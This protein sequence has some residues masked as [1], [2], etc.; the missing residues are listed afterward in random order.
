VRG[1]ATTAVNDTVLSDQ[2]LEKTVEIGYQGIDNVIAFTAL[3]TVPQAYRDNQL[4]IPTG[5]LTYEFN[6]YHLY[7][8]QTR[9]LTRP[10]SQPITGPWSFQ[11]EGNLP[12]HPGDTG[13]G[14]RDG[15]LFG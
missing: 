9:E 12:S 6:N 10:E 1:R 13:W 8:P 5:Y 15:R 11:F 3:I 14:L 7:N 4:E 2:I